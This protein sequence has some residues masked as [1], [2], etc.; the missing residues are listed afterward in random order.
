MLAKQVWRAD[1]VPKACWLNR[2]TSDSKQFYCI[3]GKGEAIHRF[4]VR[5]G[6][7]YK[8]TDLKKYEMPRFGIGFAV[9]PDDS[10]LLVRDIG[11]QEIYALDWQR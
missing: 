10:P 2:W 5:T 3:E 8:L 9:A 6:R 4:D 1:I 7:S 11:I